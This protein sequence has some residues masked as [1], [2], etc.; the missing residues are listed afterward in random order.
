MFVNGDGVVR[1][2]VLAYMLFD[3]ASDYDVDAERERDH[4]VSSM[5][6]LQIARANRLARLARRGDMA[7]LLN[8]M[9]KGAFS[10][11]E[12]PTSD[13]WNIWHQRDLVS[14]AQRAL[15]ELGYDPGPTDG[16]MGEKTDL[17]VRAFQEQAGL[18]VDGQ[19]R[20]SLLEA[21]YSAYDGRLGDHQISFRT[22]ALLEN[23]ERWGVAELHL[24]HLFIPTTGAFWSCP[25]RS[26]RCS[27][28]PMPWP[29][30]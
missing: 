2:E 20:E 6:P 4:L 27:A 25:R 9:E 19:I 17:A 22:R 15:A 13:N 5:S 23:R 18:E 29:W 1:D 8:Q 11:T 7:A 28:R 12:R 14:M 10:E 16:I 3:L 24:G 30:S 21:L 26:S